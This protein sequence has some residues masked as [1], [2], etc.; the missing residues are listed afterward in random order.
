[1]VC[2]LQLIYSFIFCIKLTVF[3]M[4]FNLPQNTNDN[5]EKPKKKWM[6]NTQLTDQT[7]SYKWYI[8]KNNFL[9]GNVFLYSHSVLLSLED[10]MVLELVSVKSWADGAA[11]QGADL[12]ILFD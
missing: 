3:Q 9:A 8:N 12:F 6:L 2:E 7:K 11:N 10:S 5:A 1:M 4:D